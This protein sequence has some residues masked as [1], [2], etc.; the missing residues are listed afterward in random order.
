MSNI[1]DHPYVYQVY[2]FVLGFVIVFRANLAYSRFWEGR[3]CLELMTSKWSDAALQSSVFDNIADKPEMDRRAFRGRMVTRAREH[4][5]SCH[6]HRHAG[7]E[8]HR[9]LRAVCAR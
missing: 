5:T 2:T 9:S 6:T 1:F 7:T 4:H 3:S 8:T